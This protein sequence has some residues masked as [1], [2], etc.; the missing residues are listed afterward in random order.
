[1]RIRI[2]FGLGARTHAGDADTFASLC[3]DLER[4]GF[5]S[6]W[7]SERVNAPGPDPL[8]ALAVAA[9]RTRRLKLG[10]SVLVLPGRNPVLLAKELASLDVLS[11]GR[12]LPAVGLGAVDPAEQA[13]F[14]VN[15]AE[16]GP[17]FDEMLPLLRRL[18]TEDDVSHHGTHHHLDGVTVRPRPIQ[19]PLEVWLGGQAP[20][21]LRRCG[22]LGDGWLPSFCDADDVAA[23]LPVVTQAAAAAG[24]SIDPGHIGA[25][26]AYRHGPLPDA[27]AAVVSRR[28]PDRDPASLIPEGH[29]ALRRRLEE[30][31]AVG[32]SKFVVL[33]LGDPVDWSAELAA[34]ADA[35]LPLQ[36][37]TG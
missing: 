25:L 31:T 12:L 24:R 16:R 5:D 9:G 32:A 20:S 15:R 13:A 8:T 23:G 19:T 14:G 2:G 21:E 3:D 6:L 33:G 36:D 18:W 11:G 17:R 22:R 35:V 1:M 4:L 34:L 7:L 10:T 37:A 29:Q 28:R 27:V 30:L 26:V